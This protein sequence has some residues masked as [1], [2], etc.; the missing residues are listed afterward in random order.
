MDTTATLPK[1]RDT[2]PKRRDTLPKRRDTLPKRRD[3]LETGSL[4]LGCYE[5]RPLPETER[6]PET[7]K[8]DDDVVSDDVIRKGKPNRAPSMG[9]DYKPKRPGKT[10]LKEK[11]GA[12]NLHKAKEDLPGPRT[13]LT[14][15][16]TDIGQVYKLQVKTS[17]QL[18][19]HQA[20]GNI[21]SLP[22]TNRGGTCS[23]TN[24]GG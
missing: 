23:S 1:R 13:F 15:N 21:G 7:D 10:C 17:S 18:K 3:T 20:L 11:S 8:N 22:S 4:L 2:L 6:L 12:H 14:P 9:P 16:T 19:T 5:A 24:R